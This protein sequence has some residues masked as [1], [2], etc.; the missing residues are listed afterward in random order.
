MYLLIL[1]SSSPIALKFKRW[2]CFEVLPNIRKSNAFGQAEEHAMVAGEATPDQVIKRMTGLLMRATDPVAIGHYS[3]TVTTMRNEKMRT[4]TAYAVPAPKPLSK[5]EQAAAN[6]KAKAEEEAALQAK[7]A[8]NAVEAR[9]VA[10]EQTLQE[11]QHK[12]MVQMM[13]DLETFGEYDV[14]LIMQRMPERFWGEGHPGDTTHNSYVIHNNG[15]YSN[16]HKAVIYRFEYDLI[17]A[18]VQRL[19]EAA[20][21]ALDA[22]I[23]AYVLKHH[24]RV[25][26]PEAKAARL[27]ERQVARADREAAAAMALAKEEILALAEPPPESKT[28]R[29][30]RLIVHPQ[31]WARRDVRLDLAT[32]G[33]P[34][35]S[36]GGALAHIDSAVISAAE[37][38]GKNE[39]LLAEI[40]VVC[41]EYGIVD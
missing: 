15:I 30:A 4:G 11:R 33:V 32:A 25:D 17:T 26:T 35:F 28:D 5:T 19:G 20:E 21:N 14:S 6:K 37:A 39:E 29:V 13:A 27:L 9:K 7:I 24:G 22:A 8:E 38:L 10:W 41:L 1:A 18:I 31:N 3:A 16:Y 40:R 12:A 23:V 36:I 34:F 2:I